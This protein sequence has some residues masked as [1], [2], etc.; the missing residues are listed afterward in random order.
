MTPL[1]SRSARSSSRIPKLRDPTGL[2][3]RD[4]DRVYR[5]PGRRGRSEHFLVLARERGS[6]ETR[7][8][9][10]VKARLGSAVLRNRVKRRLREILR[11]SLEALPPGWDVVVQPRTPKVAQADFAALSRELEE[12]LRKT[13]CATESP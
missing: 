5:A 3:T 9:L 4:F 1:P 6:G 12:L 8:G 13:L 2:T 11:R 10:S 7:W